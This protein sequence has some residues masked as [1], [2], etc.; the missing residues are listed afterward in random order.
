LILAAAIA[1]VALIVIG[2]AIVLERAGYER[3]QWIGDVVRRD[4]N[5]ALAFEA[6][7]VRALESADQLLAFLKYEWEQNG[8]LVSLRELVTHGTVEDGAFTS[9]TV[10]DA[11]GHPLLPSGEPSPIRLADRPFF[12]F[13]RA[14]ANGG[15]YISA[16]LVGQITGR[17]VISLS[18][19][20][21]RPDGSMDGVY[22][23]GV[24]PKYFLES[25]R[26]LGLGPESVVQLV[27]L[28]GI[29]RVRH[30]G[31][32]TTFGQDMG[33]SRLLEL[34]RRAPKGNFESAGW[35]EGVKRYMSYRRLEQYP[36]IVAVGTSIPHVESQIA[37]R[38]RVYYL[39][40]TG[41]T[42][43]LGL[44]AGV[45]VFAARREGAAIARVQESEA[46]FRSLTEL[47]LDF[48]WETDAEHRLLE[49]TRSATHEA[50]DPP[51]SQIGLRRWEIPF[52]T[53]DEAGWQA[54]RAALD[55]RQPF[56][57]F[58]VSRRDAGGAERFISIS[59]DP[60]FDA[61]GAFRGYRGVG[62]DITGRKRAERELLERLEELQRLTD[63]CID[64][65]IRLEELETEIGRLKGRRA[66]EAA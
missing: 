8:R 14:N 34:A 30:V 55:A 51:D 19:R 50:I 16:P 17:P 49:T 26:H 48:Y 46:R 32:S 20:L 23:L 39:G 13:H 10:V 59:S 33:A 27:G 54:H 9:L 63:V 5:L 44:L 47:S 61:A 4:S 42:A 3:K 62:T 1:C 28:D 2:W 53:P 43:L 57:G 12:T 37:G 64:R 65:E 66:E 11:Q 7:T 35:T 38:I 22:L 45:L 56:R 6:Q 52:L 40:A 25:H 58:E 41:G 36:L 31:E 24:A 60:V 15:L 21:N 18:R 29:A